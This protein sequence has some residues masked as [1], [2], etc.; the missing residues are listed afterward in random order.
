MTNVMGAS[1][2]QLVA[3]YTPVALGGLIISMVGGL[4]LHKISG[5]L[6]IIIAHVCV[7]LYPLVFALMP[8][9]ADYWHYTFWA[10]I[11]CTVAIDITFTTTNIFVRLLPFSHP[12]PRNSVL[13]TSPRSPP[14]FRSRARALPAASSTL[15]CISASPSV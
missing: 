11:A 2:M 8:L 13:M 1:P 3:W 9:G 6:L 15:F 14:P 12:P 5:T 7:V 10:M 4:V